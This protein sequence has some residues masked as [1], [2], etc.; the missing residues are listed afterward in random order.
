M[1]YLK[2]HTL[3]PIQYE[4]FYRNGLTTRY[5]DRPCYHI[6]NG[7]YMNWF[8]NHK[9]EGFEFDIL[10]WAIAILIVVKGAG[11][12]SVDAWMQRKLVK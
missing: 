1:S 3:H 4:L 12:W 7:F 8:G 11:R 6:R 10:F 2:P 9:G 5:I